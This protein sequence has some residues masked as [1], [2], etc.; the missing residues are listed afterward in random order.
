MRRFFMDD[1]RVCHD[2]EVELNTAAT[3]TEM[4]DNLIEI[5]HPLLV[6]LYERFRFFELPLELVR[7]EVGR[8]RANRF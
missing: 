5:L 8:M 2:A 1:T 3:A 6:P 4:N 7:A